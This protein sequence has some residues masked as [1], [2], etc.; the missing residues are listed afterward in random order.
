MTTSLLLAKSEALGAL[1]STRKQRP[2][3][4]AASLAEAASTRPPASSRD[5]RGVRLLRTSW[6]KGSPT[7]RQK[8]RG[9]SRSQFSL[10]ASAPPS[11]P[12][13]TAPGCTPGR[14]FKSPISTP[15]AGDL[16]ARAP[17]QRDAR[18]WRG[19]GRLAWADRRL[20][21]AGGNVRIAELPAADR[22]TGAR[23]P[24]TRTVASGA[25][26]GS[27]TP[28]TYRPIGYPLLWSSRRSSTMMAKVAE[29]AV[30][31]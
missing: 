7:P 6:S 19:A 5:G 16:L 22:G 2:R 24:E 15:R 14:S 31:G 28:L 17:G 10:T 9:T 3:G 4:A 8:D 21:E 27:T 23:L 1:G 13:G 12:I 26:G 30:I 29:A 20:C 25:S 11:S 18:L